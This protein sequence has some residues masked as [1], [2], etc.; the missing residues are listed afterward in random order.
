MNATRT[1]FAISLAAALAAAACGTTTAP[2]M[3]P[4]SMNEPPAPMAPPEPAPPPPPPPPPQTARYRVT[5]DARW[6]R[7]THPVD[8][9]GSAHFSPLV[10]ANHDA[11]LT[12]WREGAPASQGIREMAE[13]GRTIQIER[14]VTAAVAAGTAERSQVGPAVNTVPAAVTMEISVSQRY[15]LYTLVTMI[16]PSPDWFVG[17]AGVPLFENGQWVSERTYQLDAWDAGTDSGQSFS[18]ADAVTSPQGVISPIVTAPL[19]PNGQTTPLGSFT[20]TRI[21]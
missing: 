3:P 16:A 2:E 6:S 12:L 14:D 5:F 11:S 19:S 1:F 4:D 13:M 20:F 10:G 17:V 18:S 21:E 15:P 8:Y 7:S 9:P